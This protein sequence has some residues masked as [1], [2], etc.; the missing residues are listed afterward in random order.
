VSSFQ[1]LDTDQLFKMKF[2]ATQALLKRMARLQDRIS[3][4]KVKFALNGL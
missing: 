2:G 3:A 1:T 4:I